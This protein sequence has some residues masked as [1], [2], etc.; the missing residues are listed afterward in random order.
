MKR[1]LTLNAIMFPSYTG[2][3]LT[4]GM[5]SKSDIVY[6]VFMSLINNSFMITNAPGQR[7]YSEIAK[8]LPIIDYHCHLD[9]RA[10]WENKPFTDITQLWLEGDHYKWRAMR[11]NGISEQKIT[12]NASAEEKFAAWA[13]TVEAS[14]GNPLYHWTHLELK[15][16][17]AIDETLNSK[18][19]RDIMARCNAQL[20]HDDFLPQALIRRSN[21]EALCTTD[22]PLDDLE[23]HR[24][25][26]AKSDFSPRVLPTFRPDELFDACPDRFLTFV[27]R[28]AQ[29]TQR[30]I[31]SLD[32]FL[33]ALEARVDFF[34]STGCRV[35]DHGLLAIRFARLMRPGRPRCFSVGWQERRWMSMPFRPGK[36]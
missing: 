26:A 2:P 16:Y 3:G 36:V 1:K 11:A 5:R 27:S 15:H 35:S 12:G 17:F 31:T 23:Y 22:G 29:K 21:V 25:L 33:A 34:H 6:G 8:A 7:L 10:I 18:N 9:A 24:L 14:F 30:A 20:R 28:L 4:L 13:Q 19:W 32:R